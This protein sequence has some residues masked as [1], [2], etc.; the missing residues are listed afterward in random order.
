MQDVFR[1]DRQNVVRVKQETLKGI[2]FDMNVFK[3]ADGTICTIANLNEISI[4]VSVKRKGGKKEILF[5]GK[6]D[7]V[8]QAIYGQTMKYAL[9][10]KKLAS[11]YKVSL[12][13]RGGVLKLNG[14]DE[15]EIIMRPNKA[16]FTDINTAISTIEVETIPAQGGSTAL[17]Q[18]E[19]ISIGSG[20]M[21]I[22]EQLG[23]GIISIMIATDFA[24]DYDTS[25]KAKIENAK[26]DAN[27]LSKDVT[28]NL[29]IAENMEML[30]LNPETPVRNLMIHRANDPREVLNN[31]R[32]KVDFT[33]AVDLNARILVVRKVFV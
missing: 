17:P 30:Q 12:D 19:I 7:E 27:G 29:L 22:D 10:I 31:V 20:K 13:F 25:D 3:T 16:A 24:T 32:L 9:C 33:K 2:L 5:N 23:S 11:G 8:L 15:L 21:S 1:F 14:D 26:L 18:V 4:D 6:L 28:G